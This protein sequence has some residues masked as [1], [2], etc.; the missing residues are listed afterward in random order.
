[1]TKGLSE[2][3]ICALQVCQ[4]SIQGYCSL[5]IIKNQN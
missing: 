5:Y 1:L 2:S 3:T 4:L